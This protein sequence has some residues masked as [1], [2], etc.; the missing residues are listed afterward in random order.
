MSGVAAQVSDDT[1]QNQRDE[2][3]D[4]DAREPE[5]QFTENANAQ[6]VNQE[7]CFGYQSTAMMLTIP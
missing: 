1:E 7:D 6:Q 3:N 4:F 2:G 5:L